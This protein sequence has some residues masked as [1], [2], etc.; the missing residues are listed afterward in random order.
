MRDEMRVI[1]ISKC[2]SIYRGISWARGLFACSRNDFIACFR[3]ARNFYVRFLCGVMQCVIFRFSLF[4]H[5]CLML[6]CPLCMTFFFRLCFHFGA[7]VK[8]CACHSDVISI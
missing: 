5:D 2:V 6:G 7:W 4:V 1:L 3:D 8:A